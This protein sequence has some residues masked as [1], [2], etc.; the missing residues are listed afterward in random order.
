MKQN[1]INNVKNAQPL[2]ALGLFAMGLVLL[3]APAAHAA[4]TADSELT[5]T[6]DAGTLSTD[7]RNASNGVVTGASF[8]M[9]DVPISN[10]QQTSTGIFG[11]NSQ[12][13]SVDNP[14]GADNG[15]VLALAA[16]SPSDT[17]TSGS[18]TYAYD[19]APS[20][21]QLTVDPSEGTITP[22]VGGDTGVTTGSPAAAFS[23]GSSITLMTASGAS[24]DIWNGYL[25][26]V[27]LSQIIPASTPAGSYSI[28]MTQ[29]LV[30][31]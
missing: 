25:T 5:Q 13:I 9:S 21:G 31:N 2:I 18:D 6:I 20:A 19:G 1:T 22:V 14:G 10:S 23:S 28:D 4:L 3:T 8:G 15:W 11:S 16:S 30:A 12:R 7:I 29:T 24:A 17:W 26:G 27:S